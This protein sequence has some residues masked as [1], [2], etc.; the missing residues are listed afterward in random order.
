MKK[1]WFILVLLLIVSIVLQTQLSAHCDLI[2]MID[3]GKRLLTGGTLLKDVFDPNSPLLFYVSLWVNRLA[4]TLSLSALDVFKCI[5]YLCVVYSLWM[6]FKLFPK[7]HRQAFILSY[8]VCLLL[9]PID[10]FTDREHWMIMLTLPYFL[11]R[12]QRVEHQNVHAFTVIIIGAFAALGFCL[13]PHF[14]IP[15]VL[16][17]ALILMWRKDWGSLFD[18]EVL[19]LIATSIAL[20]LG[21]AVQMP[22]YYNDIL[23]W[24]MRWYARNHHPFAL[25]THTGF[26]TFV[27][28]SGCFIFTYRSTSRIEKLLFVITLGFELAFLLQGK[29]WFYHML[30]IMTYCILLTTLF[31]CERKRIGY[32]LF[33]YIFLIIL[34]P[35]YCNYVQKVSCYRH[36]TCTYQPLVR[37]IQEHAIPGESVFFFTT[38]MSLSIPATYY[39][40]TELGSRFSY[41]WFIASIVHRQQAMHGV[42]DETCKQATQDAFKYINEDFTRYK[43]VVV[44]VKDPHKKPYLYQAFDYLSFMKGS[45]EFKTLWKNYRYERTVDD[46]DVYLKW[47]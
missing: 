35:I 21:S 46:Y 9:L 23:P 39:T 41:L 42:C 18:P 38:L 17:E 6:S 44:F 29:G 12:Y 28:L 45:P 14:F 1:F 16:T 5:V 10:Y 47:K 26:F 8:A 33:A 13:K 19:I 7:P 43:P 32:C 24:V 4:E 25:F 34:Y 37:A 2:Y 22:G 15:L 3:S 36:H 27:V 40:H 20:T 11:L 30:P 31:I